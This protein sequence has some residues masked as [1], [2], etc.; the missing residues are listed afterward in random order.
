MIEPTLANF[1]ILFPEFVDVDDARVELFLNMTID[2]MNDGDCYGK[3]TLY[4]TAHE[5]SLSLQRES[6]DGDSSSGAGALTSASADGLSVGF[7]TVDWAN[8]AEGSYWAKTPYGQSYVQAVAECGIGGRVAG[9]C[10]SYQ[11]C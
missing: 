11:C 9:G 7:A 5:L 10:S 1:R 4:R 3:A 2:V 8:S 6:G